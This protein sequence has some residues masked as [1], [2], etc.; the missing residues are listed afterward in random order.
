[1]PKILIVDDDPIF[2][3]QLEL[4]TDKLG[5]GS[6]FANSLQEGVEACTARDFDVVFLD[7]NLPDISG[8]KGIRSFKDTPSSPEVIIITSD[9][10]PDGAELALRNGAWY[11]MEKPLAY[12]S[13]QLILGRALQFR[14]SSRLIVESSS[15][16]RTGIIGNDPKLKS[17]LTSIF[18]AAKSA[19]NILIMG[20]TGTGKELLARA[21]HANSPRKDH[22]FVV[23][24]CT[25]IPE[26]LAESILFG[27]EKGAFTD[28]RK[29]NKGLIAQA[30]KG[31]VFLDEVGDL[32]LQV[33]RSLLRTIQEKRF[34]PVGSGEERK[35]DCRF[36]AAT[37][38]NLETMVTDGT[39]RSDLYYRLATFTIH[40]PALRARRKDIAD[41]S[42]HYADKICKENNLQPKEL[43]SDF[44]DALH[45]NDWPGNVRELIN[46]LYASIA[47]AGFDHTLSPHHLPTEFKVSYIQST[48]GT[49]SPQHEL[50]VAPPLSLPS[51]KEYR[52]VRL[53]KIE[54]EYIEQLI[55][56]SGGNPSQACEIA[57]ISRSRLY[58]L[59]RKFGQSMKSSLT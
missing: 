14:E 15:F 42:R 8:L 21:A 46:A 31:T 49:S 40:A 19:G 45:A 51:F 54:R 36:V 11:Y 34:R 9:S 29:K 58:Q 28:A 53:D 47:N 24:D 43:S 52:Q 22:P 32:P 48:L 25:N 18:L 56:L 16:D 35:I 39:F 44:L 7:V 4:Y 57:D 37:N 17:S 5:Y 30:N 59:L 23:V 20:E 13:V 2:C 27:H 38:Q 1:M 50:P 26:T 33:Q 55:P 6:A 10:D 41:I 3:K 12:R